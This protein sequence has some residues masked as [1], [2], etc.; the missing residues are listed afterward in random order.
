MRMTEAKWIALARKKMFRFALQKFTPFGRHL[1]MANS[2]KAPP[3]KPIV[4]MHQYNG[5]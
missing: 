5:L 3:K 2:T 4:P 1:I